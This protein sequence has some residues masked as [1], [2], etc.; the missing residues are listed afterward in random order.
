MLSYDSIFSKLTCEGATPMLE[1]SFD[2]IK[3]A[4]K[5]DGEEFFLTLTYDDLQE[6]IRIQKLRDLLNESLSILVCFEEDGLRVQEIENFCQYLFKNTEAVQNLQFGIHKVKKLSDEPVRILFSG[7]LPIN[8]LE[9]AMESSLY[10]YIQ[11]HKEELQKEFIAVRKKLSQELCVPILP[12]KNYPD[13]SLEKNSVHLL[14]RTNKKTLCTCRM[15]EEK[16]PK[17]FIGE[18]L[19][20]LY[21]AYKKLANVV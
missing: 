13:D 8:Q 10:D 2:A 14:D 5:L 18:Y 6:E 20:K 17:K 9:I 1:L 16:D 21:Y 12:V 11:E 7:I 3:E 4:L 15:Q 19:T